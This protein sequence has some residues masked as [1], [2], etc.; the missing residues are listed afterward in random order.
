MIGWQFTMNLK[1][2]ER[3]QSWPNLNYNPGILN[4]ELRKTSVRIVD[5]P[6][7]R[8]EHLPNTSKKL[9]RLSRLAG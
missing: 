4:D 6:G 7:V 3:K 9:Y 8:T 5:V 2:D 1:E